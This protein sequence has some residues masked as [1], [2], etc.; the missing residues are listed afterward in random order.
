MVSLYNNLI[1][2]WQV[3]DAENVRPIKPEIDADLTWSNSWRNPK[4]FM[5][6]NIIMIK[7]YISV[8]K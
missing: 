8:T 6:I 7:L 5:E 2:I 1:I 4:K 3:E